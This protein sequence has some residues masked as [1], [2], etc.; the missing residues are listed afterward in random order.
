MLGISGVARGTCRGGYGPGSVPRF[1]AH[2]GSHLL[3]IPR[4]VILGNWSSPSSGCSPTGQGCFLGSAKT[5]LCRS[6]SESAEEG[7]DGRLGG[8][9]D[10][11]TQSYCSYWLHTHLCVRR[12]F[13]TRPPRTISVDAIFNYLKPFCEKIISNFQSTALTGKENQFNRQSFLLCF[14]FK[15]LKMQ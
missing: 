8:W 14:P 3:V 11:Q 7:V 15:V 10:R 9:T 12:H 2:L 6:G 4:Y 1:R 5:E 13:R